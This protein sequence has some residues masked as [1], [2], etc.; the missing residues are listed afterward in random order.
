MSE[1]FAWATENIGLC[2]PRWALNVFTFLLP[3]GWGL[4]WVFGWALREERRR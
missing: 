3:L 4:A 1:F 2:V